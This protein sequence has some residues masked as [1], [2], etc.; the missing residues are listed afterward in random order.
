MVESEILRLAHFDLAH[1][2]PSLIYLERPLSGSNSVGRMPASQAGLLRVESRPPFREVPPF[3][4]A[5]V[6]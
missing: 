6:G 5:F 4:K 1:K 3:Q 2:A